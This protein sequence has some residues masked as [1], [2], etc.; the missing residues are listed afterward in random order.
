MTLFLRSTLAACC[1]L[2][3][4]PLV[5]AADSNAD[6]IFFGGPI[7]TVNAKNEEVDALAVQNGK[8][9]ALGKKD[10]ITKQWQSKSTKL[11]D[12]KGQTL[13]PGFV[14]PHVHIM[15]TAV[16]EGLG[17]NLSNFTLPYDT[18]DT[19]SQKLK[20][21]LKNV[22]PGGWLFGFGVDPSRTTPFMAE[23]TADELD[24]VSKDVPI[25]IV[26]QSGH[27]AYVNHKALELAGVTD[28][29]PNPAGGGVYVKDAKGKLTGKLIEPP[30]FLPFMA[31]MP[32]PSEAQLFSAVQGTMKK[33]ASTGVTSASEM[34]V[35]GNFGVDKEIAIYKNIFAKNASPIR[36]RGYLFSQA[37]PAGY[38]T[39]KPNDGDDKL[40]FIGIKYITDGSTQGLTAALNDPYS[41]PKGSK[42]SG[43]LNYKDAE[44]YAS[45]KSYFDQG[46]QI[47]SHSNGDKAIDQA[48]NSYSKLLAG[49]PK[50][51]E[52]RL[53][54]EHFT[55]NHESQVKKAVQL[56]VIPSFTI[57]HVNYWGAAFHDHIIGPERAKRID[58]AGDFKRAGGKFTL[59]SDS[60]V[61][62]VG[63]LNYVSEEVTR[64]WQL[65]PQKVLG[66]TQTVTVDDAI[67]AITID[68]AYQIFADNIVGSLEVG[69]QAD[70]VVLEKNPRKTPPADI[71]N[72]KVKETWIDGKQVSW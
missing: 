69:K 23:L 51:Q 17:L 26:N 1:M 44:I 48:L 72:I 43:A 12:L 60:P 24:K 11:I 21:G 7:V 67:R 55:V 16:F 35:G 27:I 32:N 25:F 71:R 49:N 29:T 33:M 15:L 61:S 30:S 63:P 10:A 46:W 13:M 65:P 37:L 3:L 5:N 50:P 38:N 56:G 36:V 6:T 68:A 20:A 57:G 8:I 70:L 52:R 9:V 45:M 2:V 40:R 31:K 47:S 42:W 34:S 28:K 64:L 62:N 41:Y 22:P 66:P 53:R 19:L 18:L 4:N 54:I 58:P 39:I 59:H 14:E